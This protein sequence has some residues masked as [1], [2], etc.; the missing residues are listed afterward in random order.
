MMTQAAVLK[1]KK[2]FFFGGLFDEH[3]AAGVS[4][5]K[6]GNMSINCG[7]TRDSLKN[8]QSF[9]EKMGMDQRKLVCVKQ[10]HGCR[11]KLVEEED[12]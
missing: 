8:R 5:R 3:I 12:A 7:D 1:D 11:V 4:Y 6:C 2:N 9:L 10:V